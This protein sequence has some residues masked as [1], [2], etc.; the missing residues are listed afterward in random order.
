MAKKPTHEELEQRVKELKNEAVRG[1]KAEQALRD[2]AVWMR[3]IF[4]SVKEAVFVL[5]PDRVFLEMNEA[6]EKAVR[7]TRFKPAKQRDR[8]IGVW[9]AV[10]IFFS[11][12]G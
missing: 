5:S 8:N 4:D 1:K 11:L 10:P 9:I 3:N 2:S 6:A 7:A 12:A